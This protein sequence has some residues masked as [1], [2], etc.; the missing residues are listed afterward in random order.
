[1]LGEVFHVDSVILETSISLHV[2]VLLPGPL[3]E[4]VVLAHED[5]LAPGELELGAS[6]SLNDIVLII[7]T[8]N[9][10]LFIFL[11]FSSKIDC[12]KHLKPDPIRI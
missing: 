7:V 4:P 5:L 8:I 2:D 1:M 12:Q 11:S 10:T 3:G 6:Q 9:F